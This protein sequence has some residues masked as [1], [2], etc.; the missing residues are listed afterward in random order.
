VEADARAC[1]LIKENLAL[2]GLKDGAR[3]FNLPVARASGRLEGPYDLVVADPPYEY[4]RAERELESLI[5]KGLLATE[6]TLVVEHS[7]RREWPAELAGKQAFLT[8]KY[9]DTAV[10][11]YR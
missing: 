5:E 8:R 3:V 9:G 2:T 1:G 11:M 10:T 7:K 6:G 4:D